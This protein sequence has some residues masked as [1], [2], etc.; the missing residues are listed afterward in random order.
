MRKQI[1]IVGAGVA[2]LTCARRL[3]ALGHD[4]VL[5]DKGRFVG[6]RVATREHEGMVFDH[7]A[8]YVRANSL[9]FEA[10]LEAWKT[11]GV[12]QDYDKERWVGAPT[13]RALAEQMAQGQDVRLES[14]VASVSRGTI[15][16]E[17]GST[18]SFDAV[19]VSAPIPQARKLLPNDSTLLSALSAETHAPCWALMLAF[20]ERIPNAIEVSDHVVWAARESDKPQRGGGERWIVH[21]TSEWSV[22]HVELTREEA[23]ERLLE[24]LRDA[25]PTFPTPTFVR[26]HRWRFARAMNPLGVD[27]VFDAKYLIGVCGDGFVGASIENAWLSGRAMAES[28]VEY[29]E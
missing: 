26:A 27:C 11:A 15:T 1:G 17:D 18:H 24:V 22:E 12:L 4:V 19:V 5:F 23:A 21:A 25:D 2:G 6:G 20:E 7:G 10:T 9:H 13:M 8:Q 16:L 3:Q 28:V 14:T 29:L